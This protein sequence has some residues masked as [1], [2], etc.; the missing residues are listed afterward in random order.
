MF[1]LYL[2]GNEKCI[3]SEWGLIRR[4]TGNRRLLSKERG[5]KQVDSEV[6]RL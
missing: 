5:F 6:K 1:S 4:M 2:A 3:G